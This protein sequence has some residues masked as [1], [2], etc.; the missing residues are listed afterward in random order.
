MISDKANLKS[1][2]FNL[3]NSVGV[4]DDITE[5]DL[6]DFKSKMKEIE[7]KVK[8][9]N[10]PK[11]ITIS[12][13]DHSV[14]KQYCSKLN[15]N[16]GDWVSKIL[17]SEINNSPLIILN[18]EDSKDSIEKEKEDLIKKYT[19]VRSKYLYKANKAI[20]S[21]DF[22]V[23]GYSIIDGKP[24]YTFDGD[25]TWLKQKYDFEEIG[26]ELLSNNSELSEKF[27]PFIDTDMDY[28]IMESSKF[29]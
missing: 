23:I 2:L 10:K 19:Y 9:K 21:K 17:L 5:S 12:G 4:V 3:L 11:T 18:D 6:N 25:M 8:E 13:K 14:I 28:F 24:I 22:N 20:M 27:L 7:K 16:I 15:L 26:L 1:D 29:K